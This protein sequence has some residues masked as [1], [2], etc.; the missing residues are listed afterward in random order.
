M[1]VFGLWE[2][3]TVF[4]DG[5]EGAFPRELACWEMWVMCVS[6][7][8]ASGRGDDA[9]GTFTGGLACLGKRSSGWEPLECTRSSYSEMA[10]NACCGCAFVGCFSCH[11]WRTCG[12]LSRCA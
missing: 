7:G 2:E 8:N 4:G 12:R 10:C 1:A 5:S 3:G 11:V 6:L 9:S